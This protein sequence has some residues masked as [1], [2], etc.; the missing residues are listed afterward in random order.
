MMAA[1]LGADTITACEE[2]RP[3]AECAEKVICDNGFSDRI[4]LVRKRSTE[5]EVGPGLDL[6]QRANILVTEV[7]DTELI[8]EGAISTYNHANQFLLTED[9]LVVP[10]MARIW[11]QVVTSPKSG[12]WWPHQPL[13]ARCPV[14]TADL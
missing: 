11:A 7:F 14:V 12:L 5:L 1:Q 6:E 13:P 2:F 4:K 9:R 8:G 3:M 10:G